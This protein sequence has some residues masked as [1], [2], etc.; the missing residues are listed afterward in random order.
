MIKNIGTK[1]LI[2]LLLS[3]SVFLYLLQY[4]LF[5][6]PSDTGFYFLQDL[7]F[8]PISVLLVTLGLNTVMV[9]RQRQLMLEKVSIVINEFF[10][11]AGMELIS[12][13]RSHIIN[14]DTLAPRLQPKASWNNQDFSDAIVFLGQTPARVR[15]NID[16]L[17]ELAK[18]L[19]SKKDQ[20]LRLFENANLMEHDRFTDMLWAVYHV[21]DELRSRPSFDQL[22]PSDLNHLSGDVQRAVQLLLVEWIEAMRQL[23]TRYPYLYS[24]AI[25]KCPLGES[26]VIVTEL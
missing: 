11:E 17:S 16:R 3:I 5:H 13:L 22:P 1:L 6:N 14:L 15:V 4:L 20:L 2:L 7:A 18:L 12:V 24:L 25:R 8:V 10:A 9:Y 21:H 19:V 23:R 26:S